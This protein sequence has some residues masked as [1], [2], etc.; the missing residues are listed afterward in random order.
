MI[1]RLMSFQMPFERVIIRDRRI[2]E[3]SVCMIDELRDLTSDL[4]DAFSC[5]VLLHA[6]FR[7]HSCYT[8]QYCTPTSI[9]TRI[10][11]VGIRTKAW[12]STRCTRG[13]NK[14][15]KPIT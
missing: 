15:A 11:Y 6:V 8:V 3:G 7:F 10:I 4:I 12:A 2:G 13:R 5:H 14:A 1:H 9:F